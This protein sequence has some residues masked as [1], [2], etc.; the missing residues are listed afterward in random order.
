VFV[1]IWEYEVPEDRVA[2]FVA[3]YGPTGGWA[4]LFARADGFVRTELIR[5]SGASTRF[6]TLDLWSSEADWQAFL[7]DWGEAYRELDAALDSVASGGT[8]LAEGSTE[9]E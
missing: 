7:A 5:G 8:L 4:R 6:V 1:R 3:A 9:G 2:A